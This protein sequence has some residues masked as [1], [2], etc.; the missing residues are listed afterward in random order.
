MRAVQWEDGLSIVD[1][2]AT[3]SPH[4]MEIA[5]YRAKIPRNSVASPIQV[6]AIWQDGNKLQV[7][8]DANSPVIDDIFVEGAEYC[9]QKTGLRQWRGEHCHGG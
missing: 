4:A 7:K 3:A 2:P 5:R 9:L 1:G 6:E 8:F